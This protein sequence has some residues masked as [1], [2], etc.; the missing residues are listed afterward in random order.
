MKKALI[1]LAVTVILFSLAGVFMYKPSLSLG[2]LK[3][4]YAT[5]SSA[6]IN[7]EGVD[8]HYRIEGKGEP[9]VLIHGTAASLHTWDELVQ[10]LKSD[11]QLIRMDLP[12]FGLTGPLQGGDYS[13]HHYVTIVNSFINK[14]QIDNAIIIG[15]SLGGNIAWNLAIEHG[16]KV[17]KLVLIDPSGIPTDEDSPFIFRV[18]QNNIGAAIIKHIL[19][20]SVIRQNIE[21]VYFDDDKV[22]DGL[23]ERYYELALRKGNRQA[24]V[25]RAKT[26]TIDNSHMLSQITQQTLIIWGRHDEWIPLRNAYKF[27]SLIP[28]SELL[29][30]EDAGHVPMEELPERTARDLKKFLQTGDNVMQ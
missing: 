23:I 25:D 16:E 19:P 7:I 18:A 10:V 5:D 21:A 20:K 28:N 13:I 22:T 24:F 17:K 9:I 12:A 29:I 8:V 4:K 6:F 15:S 27:D 11:Y 3:Q 1:A 2:Y 26:Q 30:Y 14:L